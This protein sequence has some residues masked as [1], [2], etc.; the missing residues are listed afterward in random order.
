MHPEEKNRQGYAGKRVTGNSQDD[1]NKG[2]PKREVYGSKQVHNTPAK[3]KGNSCCDEQNRRRLGDTVHQGGQTRPESDLLQDLAKE[4]NQKEAATEE[5][6]GIERISRR[7]RK[8]TE[9]ICISGK[10]RREER[11]PLTLTRKKLRRNICEGVMPGEG[12][13]RWNSTLLDLMG[14]L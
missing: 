8:D 13:D 1:R 3:K 10:N 4:W 5:G 11:N 6:V 7:T 14:G 2:F 9:Q 12:G